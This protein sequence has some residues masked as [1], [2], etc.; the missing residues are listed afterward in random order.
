MLLLL[1]KFKPVS[2]GMSVLCVVSVYE[3]AS[4]DYITAE[5]PPSDGKYSF[6]AACYACVSLLL[7]GRSY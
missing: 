3:G 1:L 4:T 5:N 6:T 2:V 7:D